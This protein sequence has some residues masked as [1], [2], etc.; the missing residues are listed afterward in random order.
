MNTD[1][2]LLGAVVGSPISHSLSPA[3]YR[4]AFASQSLAG[5]YDAMEADASNIADV[6]SQLRQRG[7]RGL[8]VTMPLKEAIIPFLD[9]IDEDARLLNAVN[10]VDFNNGVATGHNTDGDGCCDALEQQGG[11]LLS[12]AHAVVLG[13][14]GTARSVALALGRRGARVAIINRTAEKAEEL[15]R[16]LAP[17]AQEAGGDIVIGSLDEISRAGVLVNTTSVG[18]NSDDLPLPANILRRNIVVLDAVYSPMETALLKAAKRAGDQT[19]DGLW[20]LIQ[21]ARRQCVYQFGWNPDAEPMREAAER[22]LAA[23][24]K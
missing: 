8:S 15:V 10:C 7:V 5:S 13:A 20:M 11:A 17:A 24:H 4:A 23:R 14:G 3:I 12:G 2:S 1:N 19:V 16:T 6:L 9:V 18:M 21:Q 22:E